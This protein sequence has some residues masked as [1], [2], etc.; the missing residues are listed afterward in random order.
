MMKK[1]IFLL[2]A[3]IFIAGC[4]GT[5][6]SDI[7]DNTDEYLGKEVTLKGT[8]SNTIKLGDLSGFTLNQDSGKISVAS[9]TLPADGDE[10]TV[11][12]VVMKEVLIGPYIQAE[13]VR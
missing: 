6:I 5:Q 2:I 12:G 13:K 10:V 3:L 7:K 8:V 1:I 9:D 4:A 11:K